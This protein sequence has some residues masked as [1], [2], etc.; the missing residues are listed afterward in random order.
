MKLNNLLLAT[1]A[2]VSLALAGCAVPGDVNAQPAVPAEAEPGP[3]LWQVSDEDT[4]IYL[5]GTIHA[6]HADINWFNDRIAQALAISDSLVTELDM[7]DPVAINLRLRQAGTFQNGATLRP[8]MAEENLQEYEAALAKLNLPAEVMDNYEPWYAALNLSMLPV[9]AAGYDPELSVEA[10][11]QEAAAGKEH[12]SLETLDDQI[13]LYDGMEMQYQ[14]EYLKATV[15]EADSII[16]L[17]EAMVMEWVEGDVDELASL[18]DDEDE[19][20]YLRDRLLIDRNA[21]WVGWI[22]QRLDQPGTVF[23]A[24]GAAHLAGEGSVQRQLEERGYTVTRVYE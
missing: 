18:I 14:L 20:S 7:S 9:F 6:M 11:L 15:D 24:V 1:G 3:A 5:F 10:V 8:L 4:T 12:E 23:I 16:P 22:E 17:V 19:D 13:E 21:N 2:A